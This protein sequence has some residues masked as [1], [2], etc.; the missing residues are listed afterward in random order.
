MDKALDVRKA[1][2]T[3]QK[4]ATRFKDNPKLAG[5]LIRKHFLYGEASANSPWGSLLTA[6]QGVPTTLGRTEYAL[7]SPD[8]P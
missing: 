6:G 4:A 7:S 5:V 3:R 1:Q 2:S 8:R